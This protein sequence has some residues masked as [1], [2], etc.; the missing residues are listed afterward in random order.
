MTI[1]GLKFQQQTKCKLHVLAVAQQDNTP[2]IYRCK[3]EVSAHFERERESLSLK[4]EAAKA[5]EVVCL[6]LI[7]SE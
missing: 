5:I 4:L 3:C 7:G 1:S 2:P 6:A